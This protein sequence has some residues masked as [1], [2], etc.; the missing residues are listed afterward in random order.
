MTVRFLFTL[1][2]LLAGLA[3]AA[4]A[5]VIDPFTYASD[6]EA[7]S[8]W[9]AIGETPVP[10]VSPDGGV[11]FTVPFADGRDRAYW[12]HEGTWDLSSASGFVLD[13]DCPDPQA[14]RSLSLYFRS[15]NGWYIWNQPLSS[16]GRQSIYLARSDF[17]TEGNPSGWDAVDMVRLSPWRG[18]AITTTLT[19]HHLAARRD[20]VYLVTAT[21]GLSAPAERSVS[22]RTTERISRWLKA[23]GVPHSAVPDTELAR[24]A[25]AAS[26]LVFPY[27]PRLP[28][29]AIDTLRGFTGRGGKLIVF[30]SPDEQLADLMQVSLGTVTNTRDIG[31]WRGMSFIEQPPP[32]VPPR[33]HQQSW[34]I[35]PAHPAT[36]NAR[37]IATWVN[38]AGEA[39]DE[40]AVIATPHG[41]WVTHVLLDDDKIAKQRLVAGLVAELV[42]DAWTSIADHLVRHAGR[43]D[44]WTDTADALLGLNLLAA[45]HP[46]RDTILA[47][48][49]RIGIHDRKMNDLYRAGNYRDAVI[50]S[51]ELTDLLIRTYGLAQTAAPGEFRG[52]WDH[53]GTGWYPGDWDRT[54]TLL[55]SSG[56][57]AIFINSTWTGLAH[58]RS[59][60]LPDSFTFRHYGDQLA[61]C[62]KA[63]RPR[64]L[65]VH[66]WI[67]CWNIENAPAEFIAPLRGTDRLQQS[68]SGNERLWLNPAHPENRTHLLNVIRELLENYELDGIHLDYI[69]Y[70]AAD[71]CFSPYTRSAFESAIG[72]NVIA[73]PSDVLAGGPQRDAFIRWRADTITSFVREVRDLMN[74]TKPAVRLSAAVWGGYP[75]VISSIGQDW[76]AWMS[77][78][79]LDFVCPM[80]YAQELGRFTALIDQQLP[81][82]GVR[83]RIYPGIGVTANESQLRGDEV[84]E[85]IL[86]LRKRDVGGFVLYDLSQSVVD[87]VLPTL[88][89]GTTKP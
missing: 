19:L 74:R 60:Y 31:R 29:G 59:A 52:I 53:D 55:Q 64:G 57:N 79:M 48:T 10:A 14:M 36:T 11:V 21:D 9:R 12:D 49:R 20:A 73:W 76:G 67:V 35:G 80:N 69:R 25:D 38:A 8:A 82:P 23:S 58:Y 26:L 66:A 15:G 6:A 65:E 72:T 63:A 34:S 88:R 43:I 47:F 24:I 86:A 44:G 45:E 7:A 22:S 83:G 30:F 28:E 27:Q 85:Q 87:D 3:H 78:G 50:Q 5:P 89:M 40:A 37:T 75:Q 17:S 32:G 56:I 70:P 1:L 42:P 81:L 68:S 61:A 62:L 13:I 4:S 16:A 51:H 46:N 54:A 2:T 18:A 77:E 39:S 71:A 33:I 41:F 84:V